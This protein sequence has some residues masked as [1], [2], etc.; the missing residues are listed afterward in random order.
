MEQ[1]RYRDLKKEDYPAVAGILSQA[2]GLHRYVSQPRL[3]QAFRQQ[4][5]YSCL[6]EATF[7]RVA[8]ENGRIIGVIMGNARSDYRI[9]SQLPFLFR[10]GWYAVKMKWIGRKERTG[11]GDYQRL[12]RIYGAFSQRHRGE[13]DGV[14]TLFAVNRESRGKGVGK[15]LLSDLRAYWEE[16]KT[17]N[18]YLYTDTTCNYGFY[19]HQGFVRL[20]DEALTLTRDG[21]PFEM[22]VFLYGYEAGKS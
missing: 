9:L 19:E 22:R 17:R 16:H 12:H 8:E 7:A 1:V 11:I 15:T 4:Y 13:F 10:S 14:L 2:F 6:A 18:V 5:V 3:L 21:N 20:E